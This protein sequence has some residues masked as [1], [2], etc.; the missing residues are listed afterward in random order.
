[1]SLKEEDEKYLHHSSIN[2]TKINDRNKRNKLTPQCCQ[3]KRKREEDTEIIKHW[4]IKEINTI[5]KIN[6][7]LINISLKFKTPKY[8]KDK[9]IINIFK[10]FQSK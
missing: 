2:Y 8:R 10:S 3:L 7:N 9:G 1:M 6:N 4:W 5:I